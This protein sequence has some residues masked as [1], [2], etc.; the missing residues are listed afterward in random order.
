MKMI[1]KEYKVKH[2]TDYS[3]FSILPMNRAIDSK[4]V[5][6][7]I[8]SLRVQGCVR[9]IICCR[10]SI[11]EGVEKTYI[12]DGQHVATALEREGQPIPYIEI[13]IQSEEE[14]IE[15]ILNNKEL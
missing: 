7:M 13:E 14:L 2:A 11:I 5:Q 4:H 6:K 12:I 3:K 9:A 1:G 8:K 10:T 15:N